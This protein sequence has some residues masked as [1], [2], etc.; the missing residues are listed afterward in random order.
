MKKIIAIMLVLAALAAL[1]VTAFATG[2]AE[3]AAAVEAVTSASVEAEETIDAAL[4]EDAALAAA[5]KDAGEKEADVTVT[6]NKLSEKTTE[7]DETIAV[8]TVKFNTDTTTYKYYVDANT[9]AILYKSIE[10][11]SAD[12]VFKSHSRGEADGR[13]DKASG[14]M[15]GSSE[16]TAETGRSGKTGGHK[17]SAAETDASAVLTGTTGA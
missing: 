5:L 12:V 15:T 11:R 1:T 8:Y 4:S 10:F 3:P 9:G 2:S 13:S 17:S 6:K 16:M 14:E 7:D